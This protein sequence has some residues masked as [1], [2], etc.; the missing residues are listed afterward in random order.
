MSIQPKTASFGALATEEAV[1]GSG[2]SH[3]EICMPVQRP[4]V[5]ATL[6][7]MDAECGDC[8]ATSV[9]ATAH[10]G[11]MAGLRVASFMPLFFD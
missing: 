3:P 7:R 1:F 10:V 9:G 6:D 2:P 8:D 5:F 11:Q 4:K